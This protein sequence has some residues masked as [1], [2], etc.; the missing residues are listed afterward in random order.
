M[1]EILSMEVILHFIYRSVREEGEEEGK[2]KGGG[3]RR[4]R[5]E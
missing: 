4:T 5:E 3:R 2:G 1:L